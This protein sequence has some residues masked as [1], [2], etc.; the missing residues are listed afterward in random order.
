MLYIVT[1]IY[2]MSE[3]AHPASQTQA[4]RLFILIASTYLCLN[5]HYRTNWNDSFNSPLGENLGM[6][7][8]LLDY[9]LNW[10][11]KK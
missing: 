6:H 4:W 7:P 11:S 8:L 9:D 10:P 5:A 2:A 3:S 1:G